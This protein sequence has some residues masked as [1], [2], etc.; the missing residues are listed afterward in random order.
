VA[1]LLRKSNKFTNEDLE[2]M[3]NL[4]FVIGRVHQV[5]NKVEQLHSMKNLSN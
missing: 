5:V 1:E 2:K 4:A 3:E